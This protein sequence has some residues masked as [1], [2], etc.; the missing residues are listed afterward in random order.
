MRQTN[1]EDRFSSNKPNR[2]GER[3]RESKERSFGLSYQHTTFLS[4]CLS[5][6]QFPLS[7]FV[8]LYV[9]RRKAVPTNID[10]KEDLLYISFFPIVDVTRPSSM[11][12]S[13]TEIH[14]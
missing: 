10:Q 12:K 14:L 8:C 6:L 13:L 4:V 5:L 7:T 11:Q 3:Q 2:R 9:Y 1:K